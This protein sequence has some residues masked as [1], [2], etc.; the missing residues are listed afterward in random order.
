MK[1]S[2]WNPLIYTALFAM[3]LPILNGFI[4]N[5][6]FDFKDWGMSI[7]IFYACMLACQYCFNLMSK[8]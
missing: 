2:F 3:M 7:L 5:R 4:L 1:H 8:K 6:A